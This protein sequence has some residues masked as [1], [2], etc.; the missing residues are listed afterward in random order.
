MHCTYNFK[1]NVFFYMA[2]VK[3]NFLSKFIF[4]VTDLH[5]NNK[6]YIFSITK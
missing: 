5:F 3:Q 2:Y 6:K 1:L 4:I